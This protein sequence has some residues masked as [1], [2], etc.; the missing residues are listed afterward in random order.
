MTRRDL[1]V[2]SLRHYW[3]I[4]SAVALGVGIAV[5]A[6]SGAFVVGESVRV[7]LR[8][9]ALARLGKAEFVVTAPNLFTSGLADRLASAPAARAGWDGV[10]PL[11]ALEGVLTH[12][13]TGG[14][15]GAVQVYGVDDR[16]WRFHGVEDVTGPAGR[17]AFLSTA[18]AGELSAAPGDALLLR[19]QKPSAIPSGIIQG[20]RND[21]GRAIRLSTER[22]LERSELGDFSPRPQ[23]GATRAVFVP[24]DRLQRDL[25]LPHRVNV[26]IASSR[27]GASPPDLQQ[28]VERHADLSDLG[29]TMRPVGEASLA[30]ES[31]AGLLSAAIERA[32]TEAARE[33][34]VEPVPVLTYL[35]TSIAA[36]GRQ[37]PYSLVTALPQGVI[38]PAVRDRSGAPSTPG[39]RPLWLTRWAADDLG[40]RPGEPITLEYYLWSDDSG[41][42]TDAAEFTVAGVLPM[43]GLA[44]D[45]DLTPVYPGMSTTPDIAEWDPPFPVDLTRIRPKD[46]D[47]WDRYRTAPKAFIRIEDGQ[48]LWSSRYGNVSSIRVPAGNRPLAELHARYRETLAKW[49]SPRSAGF[50]AIAVREQALTAAAGTTDFG[51][52][53]TYFSFFIVVSS[54]L[55]TFLFFRLGI[56]QRAREVG[57]LAAVGYTPRTIR[58]DL[59]TEGLV[60]ALIGAATGAAGAV[61]YA[62]LIMFALRT[63]WVGAVGT[64]DLT[65]HAS[66]TPLIAGGLLAVAA[67]LL[68]IA[69]S[70]RVLGRASTRQLM[71]GAW[72][73]VEDRRGRGSRAYAAIGLA[74]AALAGVLLLTAFAGWMP[75]AGAFFGSGGLLLI[76]GLAALN[77]WLRGTSRDPFV[78]SRWPI[79]RLGLR[80]ARYRPSRSVLSAALIAAA[81]FLIVSV[82]AFRRGAEDTNDARSGTGGYTLIAE[83]VV[84]LMHDPSTAEG[85]DALGLDPQLARI[86]MARFRLRPGDDASC[87]N[88]YRPQNPRLLGATERFVRAN[89]FSFAGSLAESEEEKT[90]PWLLLERRFPDGAV[91]VIGDATSLAYVFHLAVGDDYVMQGPGGSPLTLRIVGALRDSVLQSE[92]IMSDAQFTRLFPRHEGYRVFLVA[93][94][95]AGAAAAAQGLEDQLRDFGMDVQ[96]TNERLASYHRVENT[97]LTTFQALGGL[98]LVLGTLGLGTVLLRNVLE[99]RREL[100]LLQA[101]GYRRLHLARMIVAESLFLLGCGLVLGTLSAAVAIAPPYFERAQRFPIV[102]TMGLLAAVLA[103]GLL[104]TIMATRAVAKLPVLEALK[105]D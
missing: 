71:T 78:E 68:F 36:N 25:D 28:A 18:L 6:L 75:P 94:D 17:G 82:G 88:L 84:P 60:L 48:A 35:A 70:L 97:Y 73:D 57:L 77:A 45:A 72:V 53:F 43:H 5:S 90:N 83:T 4:N 63:W 54:L 44:V 56:E 12:E 24:L 98:G 7:S 103:T 22:V 37:I 102:G 9:L 99:R 69:W 59:L 40:V 79:A 30:V 13:R 67:G 32:A 86:E 62:W 15:A 105:N 95:A 31:D 39:A 85:R 33:V 34:G 38:A 52:Y 104:S 58:A 81:T 89:R 61:A 16:F 41:L 10:V 66:A 51:E 50:Q 87:L 49:L 80:T 1:V 96:S 14:R 20:R 29:V 3:R 65:L 46:E 19:V 8:E 76:A 93:S 92:L 21:P 74:S 101:T 55:L 100:A 26:L 47:Y 11:L 91:P 27:P 23:Q 42:T 2:R 64:T